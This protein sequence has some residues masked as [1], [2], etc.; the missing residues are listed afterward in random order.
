MG[1]RASCRK[2]PDSVSLIP[3][4]A[5]PLGRGMALHCLVLGPPGRGGGRLVVD[6]I[7]WWP[8]SCVML[9]SQNSS[10]GSP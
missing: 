8:W 2:L 6:E 3:G 10:Q 4:G 7:T 5:T 1:T 9:C